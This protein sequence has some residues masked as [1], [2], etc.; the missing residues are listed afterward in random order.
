MRRDT[1]IQ[2]FALGCLLAFIVGGGLLATQVSSSAGR[3]RL[4]YAD[5]AEDGDPPEVSLGIAMGAFRGMFVNWLWIRANDL[6]EAGKYHE[7]VD[8][9][10]TITRL[11][12][13]FPRVWAFHAWN[14]AYNIS[15]STNT[16]Q[17]RWNW[18]KAGIDLVRKEGIP[19]NPSSTIV[20]REI[21][22]IHLHKIQG[23]MDDAHQYYKRQFAYDWTIALGTPPRFPKDLTDPQARA[24]YYVDEW[25]RPI[26]DAPDSLD[27]LYAKHPS[28][29]ALVGRLER[30]ANTKPDTTLLEAVEVQRSLAKMAAG[31]GN[32]SPVSIPGRLGEIIADPA[33]AQDG[34]LLVRTIRKV[35]LRDEYRMDIDRMIKYTLEYGPLDWRHASAHAVYWTVTGAD[36]AILRM[37]EKN[38]GDSDLVN[39]DRMT[40]QS[41]QDLFRTG[42][43]YFDILNPQFFRELPNLDYT[44]KYGMVMKERRDRSKFDSDTKI[45]S[46]YAAGYENFMRDAIRYL[47]RRGDKEKAAVYFQSLRTDPNLNMNAEERRRTLSMTLADFVVDEIKRDDRET[48][49]VVALQEITGAFISAYTDGLLAQ[50]KKTFE[51]N[52][53]YA[54]TFYQVFQDKQN[55]KTFTSASSS[56]SGRLGF[57]PFEFMAAQVL[58]GMVEEGGIPDGSF[59]YRAAMT[60]QPE[61]AGRAY[62]FLERTTTKAQMDAAVAAHKDENTPG[63]RPFDYW[64]PPPAERDLVRYRAEMQAAT[65]GLSNNAGQLEQ[66]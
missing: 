48:S 46:F 60:A 64:F 59:M 17:E 27:E 65:K 36:E 20:Y 2:I 31:L 45:Y 14:L 23:I 11:Q 26:A 49:P 29:K 47:Y 10:R 56:A 9:A 22:W 3:N 42:T 38:Q 16:P 7:A 32:A 55:F 24:Q 4:V 39:I 1:V 41:L 21:A 30:E 37:N 53:S 52:L 34:Q 6:K 35:H 61:L 5:A 43:I 15:V 25:L 66:K 62:T 54:K 51:E 50:N 13:R 44:D 63:P 58:A 57:P 18:V 12:P 40:V 19:A 33:T 8:L 28:V